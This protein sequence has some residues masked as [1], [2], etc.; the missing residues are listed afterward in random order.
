MRMPLIEFERLI[1]ESVLKRGLT[2]FKKG[3][4]IQYEEITVGKYE[5]VVAGTEDYTTCRITA[6]PLMQD[7]MAISSSAW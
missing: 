6:A 3:L 2:Y 7:A 1:D 5:A 4:V